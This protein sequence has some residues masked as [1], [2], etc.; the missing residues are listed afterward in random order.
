MSTKN[1]RKKIRLTLDN[2][3]KWFNYKSNNKITLE[4]SDTYDSEKTI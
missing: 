1:K 2:V 3:K 4:K